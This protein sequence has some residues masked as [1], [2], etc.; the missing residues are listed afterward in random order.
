MGL[1]S[2][3]RVRRVLGRGVRLACPRCGAGRLFAG[4]FRMHRRCAACGL[5]FERESGYFVGAIYVN[6]GITV[7]I[8]LLGYFALDAWLGLSVGWQLLLWGAFTVVF[9][10]WF[11]RYSKALWL[12]LDHLVDPVDT[13]SGEG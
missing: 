7:T 10:L 6:Y 9:P 8:A 5:V 11:F 4:P 1:G 3:G 13:S 2:L 12:S